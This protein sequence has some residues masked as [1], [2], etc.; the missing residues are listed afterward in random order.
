MCVTHSLGEDIAASPGDDRRKQ[1]IANGA[2]GAL[3]LAV[4]A[5]GGYLASLVHL[6]LPW[7]I[8]AMISCAVQVWIT[9]GFL[10]PG[11]RPLALI[12]LGLGLGQS[13]TS[14]ILS[15]VASALPIVVLAGVST[16]CVGVVF[17]RLFAR[18]AG[19]DTKT[20]YYCAV[21]G[22]VIVMAIQAERIGADVATVTF[23]QSIRLVVVVLTIPPL[24][25]LSGISHH[26]DFPMNSAAPPVHALALAGML[27]AGFFCARIGNRLHLTNPWMI[28]PCFMAVTLCSFDALPS[29]VP[30]PMIDAAQAVLGTALGIRLTREFLLRSWHLLVASVIS[31]LALAATLATLAV[32]L[33][34]LSGLPTAAVILGMAPGGMPEMSLTARALDAPVALVLGF[35]LVRV[36][37]SNLLIEPIWSLASRLGMAR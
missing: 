12:V 16:I 28:M 24:L 20:G 32:V 23:T 25:A 22:G 8:G 7:M 37:L 19:T 1:L 6:P 9:P 31:T 36:V 11:A 14:T 2:R 17:S 30:V 5:L 18:L 33:A 27:V 26:G 4:G 34:W 35:H 29:G 10:W 13:F 15:A 3:T 21:P